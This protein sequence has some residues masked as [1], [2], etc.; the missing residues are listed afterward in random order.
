[1]ACNLTLISHKR[2]VCYEEETIHLF[3]TTRGGRRR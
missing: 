2:Y 1:M 3:M